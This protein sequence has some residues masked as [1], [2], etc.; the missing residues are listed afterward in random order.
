MLL[1]PEGVATFTATVG[2]G[3]K[4]ARSVPQDGDVILSGLGGTSRGRDRVPYAS[5]VHS[6]EMLVTQRQQTPGPSRYG[7]STRLHGAAL[8]SGSIKG[9]REHRATA[10]AAPENS[11]RTRGRAVTVGSP[12]APVRVLRLW[13]D[14][15]TGR[16]AVSALLPPP[17]RAGL[18]LRRHLV[19]GLR[20]GS[21][22][23]VASG[24]ARVAARGVNSM[25]LITGSVIHRREMTDRSW[26]ANPAGPYPTQGPSD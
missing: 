1:D 6:A 16:T 26:P 12:N 14:S 17:P 25:A 19:Q 3:P 15:I 21:R 8:A 24:T 7:S 13:A 5:G 4:V 22:F 2:V 10:T 23:S 20:V 11:C 18:P 9:R